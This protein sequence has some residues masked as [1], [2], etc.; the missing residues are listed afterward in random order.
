MGLKSFYPVHLLW[1]EGPIHQ[2]MWQLYIC[3]NLILY[4]WGSTNSHFVVDLNYYFFC[5]PLDHNR[6]SVQQS[7]ASKR[8]LLVPFKLPLQHVYQPLRA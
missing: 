6:L 4:L 3:T 7:I 5:L 2:F 1:M 8:L